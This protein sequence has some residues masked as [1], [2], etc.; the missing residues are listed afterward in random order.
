M[1][2]KNA[3]LNINGV[4]LTSD[5]IKLSSKCAEIPLVETLV[6][7]GFSAQWESDGFALL[8]YGDKTVSLSL[9]EKTL[10][11]LDTGDNLLIMAPGSKFFCCNTVDNDIVIDT[12]TFENALRFLGLNATLSVND[13]QAVIYLSINA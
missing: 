7:C 8:T 11:D 12:V 5:K 1:H 9:S 2:S 10:I 3:T 6:C 13:E 4:L